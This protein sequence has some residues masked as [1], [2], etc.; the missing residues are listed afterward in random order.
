MG[1]DGNANQL[2][3]VDVFCVTILP[4]WVCNLEVVQ[5]KLTKARHR[6]GFFVCGLLKLADFLDVI[7][8]KS[9]TTLPVHIPRCDGFSGPDICAP[10]CTKR[11]SCKRFIASTDWDV[12]NLS[13]AQRAEIPRVHGIENC[14]S[15][16]EI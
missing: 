4:D 13:S 2:D 8:V 14:P 10:I 11:A 3:S 15:Y 7:R 1:L 5:N 6:A 12:K 16:L 9:M